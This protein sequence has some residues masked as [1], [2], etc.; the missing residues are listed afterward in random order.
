LHPSKVAVITVAVA[1]VDEEEEEASLRP[2]PVQREVAEVHHS[3]PRLCEVSAGD[4]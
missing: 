3:I 1:A 2:V 4:G